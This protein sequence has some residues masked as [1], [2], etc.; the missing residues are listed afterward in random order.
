MPA[1]SIAENIYRIPVPLGNTPL[2][3]LNAYLIKGEG[4]NLLIDTGFRRE[5]CWTAL[6]S[7][8]EEI[9]VDIE[10]TDIFLTH[11]HSDHSG[12]APD[13]ISGKRNIFISAVDLPYVADRHKSDELDSYNRD[14]CRKGGMPQELLERFYDTDGTRE[15]APRSG[16]PR[17]VGLSDGYVFEIAGYSFQCIL[18]PGHT[19][20]HMCLWEKGRQIMFTG[21]HV[22]FDITPNIVCWQGFD[23]PLGQ[24]LNSLEQIGRYDVKLAL[25]GHRKSGDLKERVQVI[26]KHHE[27]RLHECMDIVATEPG[28]TAYDLARKMKWRIRANSW[29]DFPISQKYFALGECQSHLVYL[30]KRR[31]LACELA[32]GT[33]HFTVISDERPVVD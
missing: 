1:E 3:E 15:V 9:G 4:R 29:E 17:Y 8:L 19:P 18:T 26:R 10:E 25:P 28:I 16:S 31:Y 24:Y 33:Y 30:T 7:G 6:L 2:K 11:L 13:I 23:D 12:N 14:R 21:D 27:A 20:G 5:D 32:G 22:L